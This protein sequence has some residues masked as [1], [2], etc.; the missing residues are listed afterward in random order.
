MF[1]EAKLESVVFG[2]HVMAPAK[3]L[4]PDQTFRE[5]WIRV[6]QQGPKVIALA[7]D[8]K[9]NEVARGSRWTLEE[10]HS[11]AGDSHD[12]HRCHYIAIARPPVRG[13]RRAH[14]GD[15][16][17]ERVVHH[18]GRRRDAGVLGA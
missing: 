3:Q 11:H 2:E 8:K 14:T 17:P 16:R 9:G 7:R 6:A 15:Y 10:K 1:C 18:P 4:K 13:H 5:F 12:V